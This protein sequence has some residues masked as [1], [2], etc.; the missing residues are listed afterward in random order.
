MDFTFSEEQQAAAE[1]A[2]GVFAGVAPDAVPPARPSP[3]APSPRRTTVS[4][5]PGSPTGR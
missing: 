2:K 1:A 3:R 4:C 5:G